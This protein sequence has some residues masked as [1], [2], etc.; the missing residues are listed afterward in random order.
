M[1]TSLIVFIV[2]ISSVSIGFSLENPHQISRVFRKTH[3]N[4]VAPVCQLCHHLTQQLVF[5][6]DASGEFIPEQFVDAV[7]PIVNDQE[8]CMRCHI[9][10]DQQSVN[11][12]VGM[13]YDPGF[14]SEKFHGQPQGIKLYHW[15]EGDVGRV[16]CST[17][18]DPHSDG[19]WML[20]VSLDDS[21][22]CLCCHNY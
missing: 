2:V 8:I 16:M 18:H 1:K 15:R 13:P 7:E 10:A 4:E 12:P 21:Q 5:D 3:Q 6:F 17:C 22:L 20:R 11:H 9:N 14:L 19:D